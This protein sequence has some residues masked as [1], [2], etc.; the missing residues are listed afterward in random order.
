MARRFIAQRTNTKTF[1]H[2]DLPLIDAEPRWELA[3]SAVWDAYIAPDVGE[4][5]A[6]DG[7]PLIDE[8]G[9]IIHLEV[10]GLIRGSWY[11]ETIDY[12]GARQ[13][14]GLIGVAGYPHGTVARVEWSRIQIDPAQV[15]RDLWT[16][17]QTY[18][19]GRCGVTVV[20]ATPV[21]I[22]TPEEDVKFTT[23]EGKDVD[24]KAGP[25][26]V[27][28][29]DGTD[30]GREIDDLAGDTPFDYT[31]ESAWNADKSDVLHTV[32]IHYPKAGRRRLD[33]SFVQGE[34]II[35]E[36]EPDGVGDEWAS[37][38]IG[39]GAGEGVGALR[40]SVG[41]VTHRLRRTR[42]IRAKDVRVEA[43]LDRII[44]D[45]LATVQGRAVPRRL[46]VRPHENAAIGAWQLG[47]EILVQ[48]R[49]PHLGQQSWWM[50]V[51][52]WSWLNAGGA[53]IEVVA[54]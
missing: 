7:L 1:L 50:R 41:V 48:A 20:G 43:R 54:V 39:I 14:V 44:S 33:L 30:I 51:V 31:V 25:Y 16:H 22:G 53:E 36:V 11:V 47:D 23:G 19:D 45:E 49:V 9:T 37:E 8:W 42:V 32:T 2:W 46:V 18:P 27:S 21:K 12:E 38:I 6:L 34:N 5:V 40:R 15:V 13:K 3:G 26:K 28:E 29:V 52:G 17:I 35:R 4:G 24:F 10:D